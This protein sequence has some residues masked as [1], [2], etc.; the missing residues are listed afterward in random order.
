MEFENR[1]LKPIIRL[2]RDWGINFY[3][4][5]IGETHYP[6]REGPA[7]TSFEAMR[8]GTIIKSQ[9]RPIMIIQYT[10]MGLG[11]LSCQNRP[12]RVEVESIVTHVLA[13][14]AFMG[15]NLALTIIF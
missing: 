7:S 11:D 9:S 14:M 8:M 6:I 15:V 12:T 3:S 10:R 1:V 5:G 4:S 13:S 2:F